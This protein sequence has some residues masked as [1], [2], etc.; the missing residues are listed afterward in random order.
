MARDELE[1]SYVWGRD[2]RGLLHPL[3]LV[4]G[5]DGYIVCPTVPEGRISKCYRVETPEGP[6]CWWPVH[7]TAVHLDDAR[8]VWG[9]IR[10][11]DA[12]EVRDRSHLGRLS[13]FDFGMRVGAGPGG[14]SD[15][16]DRDTSSKLSDHQ[17]RTNAR[18]L[19]TAKLAFAWLRGRALSTTSKGHS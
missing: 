17:C 2:H 13:A 18:D 16:I 4:V 5:S 1:T 3:R 12:W 9:G 7:D 11:G 10:Q 14:W 19:V 15:M 6:L 8:A